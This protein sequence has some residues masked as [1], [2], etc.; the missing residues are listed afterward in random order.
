MR[1]HNYLVV[2]LMTVLFLCMQN[3]VVA[4]ENPNK[5][6]FVFS[7][8]G[9]YLAKL[10]QTSRKT[11]IKIHET[12]GMETVAQWQI[13]DF[14]PHTVQF[15][16]HES[17]Q[18]LIADKKQLLVYELKTGKPVV[19]LSKPELKGQTIV[20][21]TFDVVKN[22]LVWATENKVYRT[23]L[24]HR[25]DRRIASIEKG[26]GVIRS[27]VPLANGKLA[28]IVRGSNKI[29]LFSSES[30]LFAE[31]LGGHRFP[32]AG[33]VSPHGQ[34]LFSLDENRD[35]LIWDMNRLKIIRTLHLADSGS[36]AKVRG[37][38]LDEPRKHLLIQTHADPGG[39]GQRY[40][41]VDLLK[42]SIDP[43]KQSV[44]ATINGNIY[45]TANLLSETKDRSA[46]A[47]DRIDRRQPV[48]Y[49][50]RRKN[51][52]YDLA[53]IEADNENYEAALSFIRRIPLDDP[54]Y[55]QSRE[56]QKR[57]KNQMELKADFDAALQEYRR[58]N[59]KSAK[60]QLENILAKN[61]DNAKAKRYLELTESKLSKGVWLKIL[62]AM[63]ILILLGLLG[64]LVWKFQDLI[65]EKLGMGKS[66]DEKE[67]KKKK[68]VN[69]RRD[70]IMQLEDTKKMLKKAVALDRGG[71][72]KDKW[73]EFSGTLT[74][75]EKRAKVKDKI[76]GDLSE[77]LSKLQQKILKLSP[78]A[79]IPQ[80]KKTSAANEAKPSSQKEEP[81]KAPKRE[82]R[83]TIEDDSQ[84]KKE[85]DYYQVL[86]IEKNATAAEIKK[87]YH[88][89]MMEYHP[90]KHNTSDF[91]WVKEE[92]ARMTAEIQEAYDV[93]SGTKK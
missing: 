69:D 67:P 48:P 8:D 2:F 1:R 44:I 93:L 54:Q 18:L 89:K 3:P 32:L 28:V 42:G 77:Q 15:S 36:V 30:P 90:D 13:P 81:K 47:I 65:R 83:G 19:I 58:G 10:F 41:I 74:H 57:V 82:S 26:K 29:H 62:L 7:S 25:Q 17:T 78:G 34:M 73:L 49:Q 39:I 21:A 11:W 33:V 87:A 91:K 14:Q 80:R 23:S 35:L 56:L 61:P 9:K 40:A 66:V 55:K 76:L 79:K 84:K 64:Y 68:V 38:S 20:N 50:P 52:F 71:K 27:V 53:K 60:I 92:A 72:F 46:T 70:F 43:D 16:P 22:H 59:L 4:I 75:I 86:G 37:V 85:P 45:S 31:E 51:S 5:S 63:L 88:K 12:D 6:Y 24:Q